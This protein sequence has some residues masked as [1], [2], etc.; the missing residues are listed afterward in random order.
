MVA[1]PNP[2]SK[3]LVVAPR[4]GAHCSPP[5]GGGVSSPPE[6]W[7]HPLQSA[8]EA[9]VPEKWVMGRQFDKWDMDVEERDGY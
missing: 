7:L 2:P 3:S 1:I 6:P 4:L 8:R 9:G 5:G